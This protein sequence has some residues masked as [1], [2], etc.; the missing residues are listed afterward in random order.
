M[1]VFVPHLYNSESRS[2]IYSADNAV[3]LHWSYRHGW[4]RREFF[5]P[6]ILG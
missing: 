6:R 1:A 3:T 4:I 2:I 5:V